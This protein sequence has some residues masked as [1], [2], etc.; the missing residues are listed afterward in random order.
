MLLELLPLELSARPLIIISTIVTIVL[1]V[2]RRAF[3]IAFRPI[4][5]ACCLLIGSI[6]TA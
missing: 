1:K 3:R 6:L 2:I 4:L 5:I